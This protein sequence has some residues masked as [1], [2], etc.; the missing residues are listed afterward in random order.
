MKSLLVVFFII[1]FPM[2]ASTQAA[3]AN[4]V[5]V[6]SKKDKAATQDIIL[7][8]LRV[9]VSKLN[10]ELESY[11]NE[12]YK[13]ELE[14]NKKYYSY[15]GEKADVNIAQFKWQRSASERLLWLVVVVVFSGVVFS[16][17][18]LWRASNIKDMIGESG[19]EVEANKIKITT[20]VVG[21]MVLAISIIFFYFFLIEVY[22]IKVIDLAPSEVKPS[23]GEVKS[24]R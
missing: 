23:I 4:T 5:K 11:R 19:I 21:V 1:F 2:I 22:R 18:Q 15:L 14:Y 16:G 13:Y 17:F 10:E 8:E 20:S 3:D 24:V 12:Q 9:E 7:Q 6:V